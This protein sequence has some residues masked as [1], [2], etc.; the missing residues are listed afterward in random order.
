MCLL[1]YRALKVHRCGIIK[2]KKKN[3]YENQLSIIFL[4]NT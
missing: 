4:K 1:V 2:I 3:C